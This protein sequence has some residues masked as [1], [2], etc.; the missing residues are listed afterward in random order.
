MASVADKARVREAMRVAGLPVLAGSPG[1]VTTLADAERLAAEIGYPLVI[2]AAAGGGGRGIALVRSR[3]ELRQAY[4]DTRAASRKLFGNGDVY[5]ER[6]VTQARHIEVQIVR[7]NAGATVHLG[8]RD[9]SVQRRNQKLIEEAPSPQLTLPMRQRLGEMAVRA[10]EELDYLGVG[11]VEFLLHPDGEMTFMEVNGRIQVEHPVT[12]MVTGI[13]VIQLQI[14]IAAGEPLPM[15]QADI[16]LRGAAIECRVNAEDPAANFRPAPGP[17]Q[18]FAPPGGPWTRVDAGYVAGDQVATQ[19]DSLL[20]KVIVWAPTRAEA[21]SRMDRALSEFTVQ[22]PGVVTTIG[23]L[24]GVLDHQTFREGVH[25]TG[26]VDAL[27]ADPQ[28]PAANAQSTPDDRAPRPSDAPPDAVDADPSGPEVKP[29]HHRHRPTVPSAS[30]APSRGR[31]ER[32]GDRHPRHRHER[33]APEP[34]VAEDTAPDG[35]TPD[36][37]SGDTDVLVG[38]PRGPG[39]EESPQPTPK[40]HDASRDLVRHPAEHD[41]SR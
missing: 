33:S 24:R 23:F 27:L 37:R 41:P 38:P 39:N 5:L 2:K 14:R 22:G 35:P 1:A 30:A 17:L 29:E 15:R 25:T 36:T 3:G 32:G 9:C 12:E 34:A 6:F 11:T 19:Y 10:A 7:D 28:H 21:L 26:L 8:E 16:E 20:A 40:T 18:V 31:G 4:T 13:D